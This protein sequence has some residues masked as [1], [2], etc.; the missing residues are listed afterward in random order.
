MRTGLLAL[1]A[2]LLAG[3]GDRTP[4]AVSDATE[5][6]SAAGSVDMAPRAAQEQAAVAKDSPVTRLVDRA[7]VRA[8]D[9]FPPGS[10]QIFLSDGTLLSDSCFETYRL[11]RWRDEGDGSITWQED[12]ADIRSRIVSVDD[13]G[14]VLELLLTSGTEQHRFVPAT[15][16]YVCPDMPR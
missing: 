5:D 14:L 3:C 10:M 16:P 8:G 12:G 1:A 7:W 9:L 15:V 2:L 13:E 11:S 6:G 4:P